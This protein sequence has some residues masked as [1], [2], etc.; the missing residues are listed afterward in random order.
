M[1]SVDICLVS[2]PQRAYNHHRPPLALM[3]IASFLE[4]HEI[5]TEIIDPK[6]DKEVFGPQKTI[7]VNQILQQINELNPKIVGITCYTPEFNDVV[8]LTMKIR[9]KKD[10]V[11]VIGGV[12]PTLRP[13]EF[14]F[15][16][17]PVD[18]VV[19][20]EGEITL[21]ELA[22]KILRKNKNVKNIPGI[23]YYDKNNN[24]Y[25]QTEAR[26]LIHDCDTMPFQA[27]EKVDMK[28]YTTPNPY[29]VRGLFL[30]SFYILVGRG[31]PSQCTFC[32]SPELRR[33]L[34]LGKSLRCRSA[35]NVVD[36]I[37]FLK[38]RYKIDAFYFIDDN[39]TLRRDLVSD[40]C[41]ELIKRR[42]NLIWSC[43]A[44]INTL[45]EEL[46]QKMKKAGCVQVDLGVESGS[47]EVLKRIKK[48]IT[49][50]QIKEIFKICHKIGMRT[51]ANILINIPDETKE[52]LSDTLKLLDIIQPSVTSFNIFIPYL[53]TEIYNQWAVGLEPQEYSLLSMA[54]RELVQNP[55]FR[56]AKHSIDLNEFY[57]L[58]HKKYNS[59][60]TFLPHYFSPYYL[61]QL[62]RSRRKAEYL[63]Q[64]KNLVK[65]Y[66]K[67]IHQK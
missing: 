25:F 18:F 20:G 26:P 8:E 53:G 1:A 66:I 46:L 34:A 22:N 37:Y 51:L 33:T 50:K 35:K 54:P 39:F 6:S 42:L 59:V 19:I 62:V 55:R 17:S 5:K 28:Y 31:C 13:K 45:S 24:E 9:E 14:F 21:Y 32:V 56:F 30:S 3:L 11:I 15:K 48:G 58:N 61:K 38:S 63:F 67:Q 52:E 44:R 36:E 41:E 60:F 64:S 27:Y 49:T 10:V 16:D 40:I 57:I 29:A 23:G 7:I 2:P 47:D 4:K 65:E 43:S 12:H